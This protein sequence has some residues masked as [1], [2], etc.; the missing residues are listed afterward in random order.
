MWKAWDFLEGCDIIIIQETWLEIENEPRIVNNLSKRYQWWAKAATRLCVKGRAMGGQI[1][2]V[3][4][5][6][7]INWCVTEWN[8]GLIIKTK[9]ASDEKEIWLISIYNNVGMREI[10]KPLKECVEDGVSVGASV[11]IV[12]DF[13]SR[14]GREQAIVECEHEGGD[15]GPRQSEDAMCNAEGRKLLSLCEE[16]G[17]AVLNGRC[18][19][20]LEGKITYIGANG[21]S[22]LDL[23][24]SVDNGENIVESIE[25]VP[26]IESDHLPVVFNLLQ[27]NEDANNG[28]RENSKVNSRTKLVWDTS[29]R[30]EYEDELDKLWKEMEETRD[31]LGGWPQMREAI[32][33]A[34][35]KMG[36]VKTVKS[37]NFNGGWF[38]GD[39]KEQRRIVWYSLKKFLRNRNEETRKTLIEDKHRLNEVYKQ[40]RKKWF[41]ERWEK[42]KIS[43]N[44]EEWWQAVRCFRSKQKRAGENISKKQWVKYF[45]QLLGAQ[46]TNSEGRD[47]E[48]V[49]AWESGEDIT[50]NENLDRIIG[51]DELKKVLRKCKNKKA[52]G[53]DGIIAEFIKAAS[54]ERIE[55]FR[56]MLNV[57]WENGKLEEGWDTARIMPIH[58]AGDEDTVSNFRGISLLNIGYKIITSVIARRLNAWIE[59]EKVLRESQ[60]GFRPGRGTRDHVFVLNALIN[61]KLKQKGGKLYVAFVDF[62]AAF[63]SVDRVLLLRKLWDKGVRGKLHKLIRAIYKKTR[64][65]VIADEGV[66]DR[67]ETERGV[68]QGCPVSPIL[69]NLFLDDIDKGWEDKKEGGSR[70]G[71][72]KIYALKYADDVA[73]VAETAG[74]LQK[75]LKTLEKFVVGAKM[76][77][78]TEKTK[79]V[80]FRKGGKMKKNEKWTYRGKDIEVVKDFKY[81]GF[82]F[83]TKNKMGRHIKN[84]AGRARKA[85]NIVWGIMK[86]AKID[87]LKER[88]QLMDSMVKAGALYGVEIWRWAK[89]E[90]IEKV[91][92]RF[93]K[94]AMGLARNTPAFLWK[95]EAGRRNIQVEARRRAGKY[96]L[97]ILGMQ[98]DRWPKICLREEVR[99][100]I[101][102]KPSQ[103]GREL[104]G[105]MREV[106]DGRLMRLI[107]DHGE[108][109]EI[110][111]ILDEGVKTIEW[112]DIQGDWTR[113]DSSSFC[114]FYPEIKTRLGRESYWDDKNLPG[115]IKEEWARLRCGNVGRDGK[116]GFGDWK[117]RVCGMEQEKLGH[118]WE[119][120]RARE[121]ISRKWVEGVD[122]IKSVRPGRDPETKVIECLTGKPILEICQYIREFRKIVRAGTDA[123]DARR[124]AISNK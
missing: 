116:N 119:C 107:W 30:E 77:V 92:G 60:A 85:I 31:Q 67:F 84:V 63:D 39:C 9:R 15:W 124:I 38:N 32:W 112:Q 46:K 26:R 108:R 97:E 81:L 96:L 102:D 87:G 3:K 42:V 73:I 66:S 22:V 122:K 5:S 64:N 34:A 109:G 41:E 69:F 82:W 6:I 2:G 59:K 105:A 75:M 123:T 47:A 44:M 7:G 17:L 53:E 100:V 48:C 93:V 106:G 83:S 65:E 114:P 70:I 86:R 10:E 95:L 90:E 1:V 43:R 91:Q 99:G 76:E 21:S 101:N 58:K 51:V 14:I 4:K 98:D 33:N 20:D 19:G 13:N 89:R 88:L 16:L 94:M 68:R 11:L 49:E 55:D 12:G 62:K 24:I 78:N 110:E 18:K 61:N 111:K 37:K 36:M 118:I 71:T 40:A 57:I 79:I 121:Q 120:E 113:A 25:V 8:F 74:D 29:K 56:K 115:D 23:I 45:G 52:P 54:K 117:C 35:G 104:Q 103:W 50:S 27:N 28:A 80:V 72:A